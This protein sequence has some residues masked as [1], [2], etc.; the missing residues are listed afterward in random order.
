MSGTCSGL[1][2]TGRSGSGSCDDGIRGGCSGGTSR[3]PIGTD[4]SVVDRGSSL[5]LGSLTVSRVMTSV[6]GVFLKAKPR[7]LRICC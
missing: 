7:Y 5:S 3:D 2:C 6:A 1:G 4:I